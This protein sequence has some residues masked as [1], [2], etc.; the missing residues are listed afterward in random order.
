MHHDAS[1]NIRQLQVFEAVARLESYSRAQQE[2]GIS[3]SAISNAMSQLE[4][5]LGFT[6]C[7]RGRGGFSLTEK[8]QQF[9]QQA[10]RVLSELNELERQSALLK[11]EHS[12]TLCISTLDSIETE[13]ALSLPVVLRSFSD[14]FPHVHIKLIIRTP[15]EQLNG[16]LNNHIDLAIG[17]Y[18]SQVHNIISEPL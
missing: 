5:Q 4:G 11:G 6:L 3:V 1:L 16:V 8:G 14:K 7:Q 10:I 18:N 17:S 9:L 13:T 12:G 15:A 2:L